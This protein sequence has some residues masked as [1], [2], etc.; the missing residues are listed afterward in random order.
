MKAFIVF[1]LLSQMFC[2]ELVNAAKSNS[3]NETLLLFT[4]DSKKEIFVNGKVMGSLKTLELTPGDYQL[5]TKESELRLKW[6]SLLKLKLYKNSKIQLEIKKGGSP[7]LTH[8]KGKVKIILDGG[9]LNYQVEKLFQFPLVSGEFLAE[10]SEKDHGAKFS[11]LHSDQ[12]IQIVEDERVQLLKEGFSLEMTPEWS[13]GEMVYDFLL[14]NKKIPRLHAVQSPIPAENMQKSEASEWKFVV[15]KKKVKK[16]SKKEELSEEQLEQKIKQVKFSKVIC[17]QP[18]G[19]YGE[20]SWEKEKSKCVRYTC[21][22]NGVWS[23]KTEFNMTTECPAKR[24]IKS[25]EWLR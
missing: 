25:C 2:I 24:Q 11:S 23:Q 17:R 9:G 6:G 20:C 3:E 19:V 5:E 4:Q 12:K 16:P 22:L 14:N 8:Q 21:N 1:I 18:N 7:E 10:L 15:E 13:D